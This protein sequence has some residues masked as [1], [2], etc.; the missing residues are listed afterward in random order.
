MIAFAAVLVG[1]QRLFGAATALFPQSVASGDPT[2]SSVILWT[3]LVSPSLA[4]NAPDPILTVQVATE[5]RFTNIVAVR[6]NLLARRAFD[7]CVK[8][9]ITGL[10]P[11]THYYYRFGY[12][13]VYSAVGRTLTAPA[14]GDA[15]PIRFAYVSCQDYIGH[16]YNT[17]ADMA[18]REVANLD[19]VL[20]IGDYIYETVNDG[21]FQNTNSFRQIQ[22]RDVAGA[23]NIGTSNAPVYGASSLDNY[24]Q[25]YETYRSDPALISIHEQAPMINI[26]DDHEYANDCSGAY[27]TDSAGRVSEYDPVR[28]RH[29]EQAYFEFIPNAFGIDDQGVAIDDSILFPNAKIYRDLG[30]GSL[31]DLVLTDYRSYRPRPLIHEDAFPGAIPMTEDV[32]SNFFGLAWPA[33]RNGF[34]PYVNIDQPAYVALK[35]ELTA[36]ARL[37]YIQGGLDTAT[38]AARAVAAV[39]GNL[40]VTVINLGLEQFGLASPFTPAVIGTLPRGISY[41]FLGKQDV[42]SDLGS[43]YL[44]VRPLYQL[45]ASWLNETVPSSENDYGDAQMAFLSATLSTNQAPWKIVTS[46]VSFCPIGFDFANSPIPLP[47]NFPSELKVNLQ[48]NADDWDGFPDQ[49]KVLMDLYGSNGAVVISGDIHASFMTTY[50]SANGNQVPEFTGPAI[51]SQTFRDGVLATANSNPLL[52]SITNIDQLIAQTD[53]LV[54]D[55]INKSGIATSLDV[56]TDAH[57]YV[58]MD[59][60]ADRVMASYRLI[61]ENEVTNDLTAPSLAGALA[62]KFETREYVVTHGASG[63]ST[64][65]LPALS[66][67]F[68]SQGVVLE[69]PATGADC[70]L[71]SADSPDA[72]DGWTAVTQTA[73]PIPGTSLIGV[74]LV[75]SGSR[76]FYRLLCPTQ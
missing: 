65:A 63:L 49:R 61:S 19:F 9:A 30:F 7:F 48:I 38:A 54:K 46:S 40:S 10:S 67:V 31:M 15:T 17:W 3:R 69:W 32:V 75:P 8:A 64:R 33:V 76:Q 23:K 35:A 72:A 2:P 22:F 28:R 73:A 5:P 37:L 51:S 52:A 42:F 1:C 56:R 4:T 12:R 68:G 55:A 36:G 74:G 70:T 18:N 57:G 50:R 20:H 16:Y 27:S 13:G 53:V 43:R 45:Y 47:S 14:P 11:H 26:W 71:Q 60:S 66:A 6:T 39:K 62:S 59:V 34:D 29:S 58:V 24:R 25:L 44:L 21:S 41:A